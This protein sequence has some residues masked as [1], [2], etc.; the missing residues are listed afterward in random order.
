MSLYDLPKDLL[1]KLITHIEDETKKKYEKRLALV[2]AKC[3]MLE[4]MSRRITVVE[5]SGP[6]CY[7]TMCCSD[8]GFDNEYLNCEYI[9]TC[10]NCGYDYCNE[11]YQ[12][13]NCEH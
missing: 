11:H 1:I 6:E 7:S 13:H 8:Y 3:K 4:K 5:C 2:E 9:D 10:D 12:S